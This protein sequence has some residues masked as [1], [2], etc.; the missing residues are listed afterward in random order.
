VT[1]RITGLLPRRRSAALACLWAVALII[2]AIAGIGCTGPSR[3]DRPDITGDDNAAK[4]RRAQELS[5]RAQEAE[6]AKRPDEAI[7]LYRQAV[8]EAPNFSAAW[9][10]LGVLLM[11]QNQNMEAAGALRRA[12]DLDIRDPRPLANL[13]ALWEQQRYFDDAATFYDQS[14]AR[15][16]N[17]LPALRN[18]IRVDD[19]RDVRSEK[20]R[21]RIR[22]A[23]QLETDPIWREYLQRQKQV[24]DGRLKDTASSLGRP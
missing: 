11:K 8:G 6:R 9:N 13:A 4:L 18:S 24:V 5:I 17:Y 2:P 14:L 23:L 20:Q 19:Q 7:A 10:N 1:T 22:T 15:D 3:A 16:P 12:A 21:D